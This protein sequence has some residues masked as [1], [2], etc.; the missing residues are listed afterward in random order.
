MA[1]MTILEA[2]EYFGVSKEAIH[3]R[4][5]RGSLEVILV[6]GVKFVNIDASLSAKKSQVQSRRK[7][8]SSTQVNDDRYYKLLEEQNTQLQAKLEKFES[9]IS[10]LRDQK[11][12]MLI[13]ERVKIEQIYRDKDE[14]LKS[15]L[16]TL[17]SELMLK[18]PVIEKEEHLEAEIEIA[19]PKKNSEL[20]SLKKYLKSQNIKEK[21]SEKIKTRFK[22]RA[23]KDSRVIILGGKYYIDIVKYDYTDLIK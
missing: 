23:K 13:E 11:E 19:E 3:N 10:S 20:I 4:V 9:E 22:K 17:S 15:I 14:Q 6:D 2:A 7:T 12:N 5:R 21:R 16:H 18:P 8:T 1:N